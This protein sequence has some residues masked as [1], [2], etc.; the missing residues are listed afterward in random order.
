MHGR[1]AAAIVLLEEREAVDPAEAPL[2]RALRETGAPEIEAH[3]AQGLA[4]RLPGSGGEEHGIAG[5]RLQSLRDLL[6]RFAFEEAGSTTLPPR[7]RALHPRKARHAGA[8]GR[9]FQLIKIL[10]RQIGAT[11]RR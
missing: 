7:R 3:R 2:G 1:P 9:V 4:R 11:H 5:L 8:L 6:A 10:A